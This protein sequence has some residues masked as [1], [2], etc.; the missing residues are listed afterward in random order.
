MIDNW[1]HPWC[2]VRNDL[3]ANL[4]SEIMQKIVH[5]GKIPETITLHIVGKKL[6]SADHGN[7]S[8]L[9]ENMPKAT[10]HEDTD[11]A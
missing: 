6:L 7:K 8:K 5:W 1:Y 11:K 9:L 10:K 3:P 4:V 2:L